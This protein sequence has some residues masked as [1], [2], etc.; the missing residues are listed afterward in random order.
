[1]VPEEGSCQFLDFSAALHS[2]CNFTSHV[3]KL[4]Q[5]SR[6]SAFWLWY[7]ETETL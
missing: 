6:I 4:C 2:V 5:D 3:T 7:K 1:M